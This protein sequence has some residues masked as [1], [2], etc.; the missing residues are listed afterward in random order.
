MK[1]LVFS[2]L[3]G[4]I[5]MMNRIIEIFEEEKCDKMI[6]LGDLLYHGPRND[7]PDGYDPKKVAILVKKYKDKFIWVR[8]NCDGRVDEMVTNIK[9]K[10]NLKIKSKSIFKN[11]LLTHG[12]LFKTINNKICFK[13]KL[14][15]KIVFYGHTHIFDVTNVKG[16]YYINPGSITIP[17][18]GNKS[19]L[20]FENN[21][22]TR[23]DEM[24][25]ILFTQIIK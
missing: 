4:S 15:T 23:Y 16:T 1:Y 14:F 12:D 2:D 3:H 18:D 17:K 20:I 7:L 24:K 13:K 21:Q 25:N 5:T 8:G 11:I 10:N 6:F 9:I 22:I 19:Y